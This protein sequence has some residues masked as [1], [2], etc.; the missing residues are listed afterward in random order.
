M[1]TLSPASQPAG[2]SSPPRPRHPLLFRSHGAILTTQ[3]Q[4]MQ[5][6][7]Q[8]RRLGRA[9]GSEQTRKAPTNL[10]FCWVKDLEEVDS[11]ATCVVGFYKQRS[12]SSSKESVAVLVHHRAVRSWCFSV[13]SF[14]CSNKIVWGWMYS[15]GGC[16]LDTDFIFNNTLLSYTPWLQM[17]KCEFTYYAL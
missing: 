8:R 11:V 5:Q 16:S 13:L 10:V 4:P 6:Q 15:I 7:Q 12:P 9:V 14:P 1:Q 2:Q 17:L 3:P